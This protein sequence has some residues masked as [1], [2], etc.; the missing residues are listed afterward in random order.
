MATKPVVI[1]DQVANV[2]VDDADKITK[3]IADLRSTHQA[4]VDA[5]QATMAAKDAEIATLKA[6]QLSDADL[7]ARV[8]QRADLVANA[9]LIAPTVDFA[10]L[11]DADLR[12]KAVVS[13]DAA[14][15]D[16]SAAYIDAMFDIKLG[17]A[18]AKGQQQQ[19]ADNVMKTFVDNQTGQKTT[20]GDELGYGAREQAMLN[21]WNKGA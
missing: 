16:K 10:G 3:F 8:A 6:A 4:A 5:H 13:L 2:A 1:G 21:A 11:S 14:F 15:A 19:T 20:M 17:E 12:K 7:D 9:K 18:K